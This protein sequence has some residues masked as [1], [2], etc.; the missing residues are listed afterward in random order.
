[1]CIPW[2][3]YSDKLLRSM[4][5]VYSLR[6]LLRQVI[7]K[8]ALCVFLEVLTQTSY[9]EVCSVCIPWGTYSD[10]LLRSMRCVYSL[11][12]LLGQVVEKYALCVFLEVLTWAGCWEVCA[13]RIPWGTY[14][15]RLLRSMRCAY[16]LR[17]LLGQVVEKYALCVFLEVLTWAGCW[18][19]CAVRIPWGTYLGRLLRS[20]RCAYSLRYLLG[21]VVEKYA[22]CVFLEVL[23]WAGCWEVCAVRI[24]W[25]TYL[26]RLL[27]SM[28]CAYSLRYLL[29]QVVEKYALCV[30]LEVLTWAGCWEVCAVCIP[31]G[32]YLGRLLRSMRCAYSLRYL[33]GQVVEKYALCVFLEVLTWAGCWEVCAVRIPWGIYLG[34][35][36][37]SM[38]CAY[39][40]RY[41]LGQVVEKYA[42]CVF[43]EVFTWAGCWEVCAVRIPWG[44][45]LGRLL[46]SMRCAY[47]LRYLLGQ[48]VE[49]YALC[50][51]LEVFTWAGCWEVCAV[52][53]P[54]GTYLGRLLRSVRCAYSL[55]HLL[56]QVV[57][58][59][60]LCVFL[61]ALT[62]A[63]CWEVCAVRIPW[64]TYLGRL[65]RSMRCAYSLRHL[66]GQVVEKYALCVF[67]EA[68]TWAGC[69][70]VCAVRIPWG[71][72]LGRLLRSMRC[73]YSLSY[74]L[75][76]V[77]EKY[78]LCV[79]LEVFT[80]AGCWEV[81][82][83]RI[84]WGIYLGRLLRSMRCAYS[85]RY[86][87]GQV[88]EKYALCVFL[89]ALTWAGCWEVCAVRIPW[90]TYLGRLLRS[91]R[92]AY[93]L[94][95]L[96]GQVVEKCALCVFLEV[97]TW[98][99]CWEVCAV[100]IPWGT[101]LGRLLRS[102]RCAYSL[103][104]LLGQVVEKYALCVFLEALTWAGCWE[105][106][107]VRIPWGTYSGRL[108][109]S[110]RCAY[111]L[112]YLL[113]QVVEKYA[114]C[115]FLEVLTRAGCWEVC[116]VRIPWGTYSG[117][118]L[119]SMRCA[120]SLRHLL[121][122]VVE[123]YALCVFLEALTRAGCWEVCAVRIPWGTYS[124]RLLRSM[125]CAYSLR[126]L[127]GQVVEKYALCV[128]LQALTW[129]G[130]WEVCAVRIPW[131][132]YLG[133]LLRSVRCAYSLRHLLGQVVE[134]CALCVFLEVLTWA[135]CWEVCAVRI[136][137]GTYLGRLLRSVRCAYSLRYLLG[138]VV[139]KYAQVVEKCALCIFLEVLT[140]AG[141][142]E[143]C[144]VRIPWGTYLGRL[145]RSVRCAYSLRYLLGQVVEK[146]A[147][148]VF[149]EVLTWAGCWEVCA[150]RIP[151]GTYLGRLLRRMRCAYSLRYL[152]GQVVEK[153]ALCVFLEVFT[154]AGCW[155][156]C[157]VRIPWGIYL[158]RLLRSVRCAYSLRYLLGQVVEKYALCVFLE[159]LTRAGCWE[160]CAVRIPW[161]T[162]SGRLL[163]NMRCAYSLRYLLGQVVEKYALCV[164]LEVLTWAGCWEVCAVRIPWGTYL[165]RLLRSMR[166][167]YS[168]RYL[169][170]Q[171]VEKYAL[172]VF[173]EVL[174]WAGYWEVCAMR[175]PWGTY[176]GRL[177]R[178]MR[179][180]YSLRYFWK[181]CVRS[182]M[183]CPVLS[184]EHCTMHFL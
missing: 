46:R 121:G 97:L 179:C 54:W 175:I 16:S 23:T 168:L 147:L 80:W 79:F 49:K 100:R 25:G 105:V 164:F 24:P 6:Y 65:L 91:V 113:G 75:G 4:R 134:K 96:L 27:R 5:C 87:L 155:E 119:R 183:G 84:P 90:G 154:W 61:E 132:T 138:Q 95:Y 77:V 109:R 76:Q 57:E 9:W 98:A 86:L 139:E 22:V 176:L 137:W 39:S 74:L 28:R 180:A 145:L 169:L 130:F 125:R 162:Y 58:K 144:A 68:L 112:R 108:L 165:G 47:S 140:W 92:C 174:T 19:V 56:G 127:L 94:R 88:V 8:Y 161:G 81:C 106:C 50:V 128:F 133:R 12:Y 32:T 33:L 85:L 171:V 60:A 40:L 45:Y 120:Y 117:R 34:R 21:Q 67:L 181:V 30:F 26:G 63:G 156:V 69:W 103:R 55:R 129:A 182:I 72:Y 118:L 62:W 122:Q 10:K 83:V 71:I 89:E 150:V 163:R 17:Y 73:A 102:M 43:L 52:R 35:L 166:C 135:G 177:L 149:L 13:V 64:G 11:R 93:S 151:W 131:G 157:A 153:Y 1:M 136:P 3:T 141:C 172:C 143:V 116:A 126:Y 51:F 111:S 184:W 44:T 173:L 152:L 37:R 18:E 101:Y 59:C 36:L 48:V 142:W 42:L 14:L 104:H 7:E 178:S 124:G 167:A 158:G 160:V 159:A 29:G 170:G 2:G 107:A 66:L 78:A 123:K 82:A 99:G 115:V 20:V 38:R 41:L 110:M 148:C 53:I 31:W 146:C 70:E 15:G 114:L